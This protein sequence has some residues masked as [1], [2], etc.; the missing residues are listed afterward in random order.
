MRQEMHYQ[1]KNSKRGSVSVFLVFIITAMIGL[2]A[3]FVY[4]AKH[5]AYTGISDGVINLAMRSILSEYDLTL[6]DRY[7]LMAFE[8]NGMESALEI[9]DYVDYTFKKD[10]PVKKIRVTFGEHSMANINNLENQ[11]NEYMKYNA[12][13]DLMKT[14]KNTERKEWKDRTLRNRG[15]INTLPS[16]PYDEGTGLIERM[17]QLKDQIKSADNIINGTSKTYIL[18]SYIMEHFKYATGGPLSEPSFYEHEVEYILAGGLSNESNREKTEKALKI[19]RT[20]LNTVYL[21]SDEKRY[22]ETLAA[23]ELLTPA[24]APATQAVIITTW[25]TAEASNDIKLLLKAKPV[26]LMKSDSTWATSLN[27]VL[28]NVSEGCI[29][30]GNEKGLYYDDYL[31]VLLHFMDKNVKLVRIADLIQINMKGIQDRDFMMKTCNDGFSLTAQIYGK[32]FS[33]ETWY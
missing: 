10:T 11:I 6:Y 12:V 21:Y 27:N 7:G 26:P 29:D 9:A 3:A 19:L 33:Y 16:R 18:D 15:L 20:A 5:K 13:R 4:A 25:A 8:K 22:A 28:N 17:E 24:S 14:E 23:A 32:E 31:M 1:M 30:T 2:A